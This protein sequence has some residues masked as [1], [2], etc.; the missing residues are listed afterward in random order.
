[1]PLDPFRAGK[2]HLLDGVTPSSIDGEALGRFQVY[3]RDPAPWSAPSG[4]RVQDGEVHGPHGPVTCRIYVPASATDIGLVWVH[5]GGFSTGDLDMPESHVVSAELTARAGAVVVSVGYRLAGDG[6]RYP[7]PIDDVEAVW[8]SVTHG[9]ELAGTEGIQRLS[10]GGA[11]AALALSTAMRV[12]DAGTPLLSALLL[13]YPFAHFPNPAPERAQ[14]GARRSPGP[15][16][17]LPGSR[18]R[19]GAQL[20]RTTDGPSAR[21]PTWR[22][23][24]AWSAARA[25]GGF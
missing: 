23:S 4:V 9:K 21:R 15:A 13:A 14:R 17:L 12:R 3:S 20:R 6:V 8:T 24:A 2:V 16:A 25:S 10:L 1:V 5:G 19:H 7:V 11:S 18:G 22:G